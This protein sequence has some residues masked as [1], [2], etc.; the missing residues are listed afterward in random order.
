MTCE[1]TPEIKLKLDLLVNAGASATGFILGT[2]MG[3]VTV[4]EDVLMVPFHQDNLKDIYRSTSQRFGE[5]LVGVIFC[6]M[7]MVKETWMMEIFFLHIQKSDIQLF[8]YTD[9]GT[10]KQIINNM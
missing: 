5:K 7:D 4:M 1:W 10:L 9:D 8:Q 6:N 2:R 3:K